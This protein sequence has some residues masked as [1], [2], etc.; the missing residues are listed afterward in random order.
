MVKILLKYRPIFYK[1]SFWRLTGIFLSALNTR[2][3]KTLPEQLACVYILGIVNVNYHV[4][5]FILTTRISVM[6]FVIN[7]EM[8][9]GFQGITYF[10]NGLIFSILTFTYLYFYPNLIFCIPFIFTT[11]H[12]VTMYFYLINLR[13][14]LWYKVS[15]MT[16]ICQEKKTRIFLFFFASAWTNPQGTL[17]GFRTLE[18]STCHYSD[19]RYEN[20]KHQE[21]KS[22]QR[23][24]EGLQ[25]LLK[26]RAIFRI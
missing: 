2:S 11:F 18:Y 13:N 16:L 3:R 12:L 8:S 1:V 5:F 6:K 20:Y 15:L 14:I 21:I 17:L 10:W 22:N 25:F 23:S 19:G 24:F 7:Y 9:I 26:G 4:N